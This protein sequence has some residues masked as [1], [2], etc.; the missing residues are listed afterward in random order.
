MRKEATLEQWK[1]LYEVTMNI[2]DLKPWEYFF[3]MDVI[4]IILPNLDEP[5]YCNIMG[6]GGEFFGIGTYA[7]FKAI[8]GFYKV[9]NNHTIPMAQIPRYQHLVMCNFGNRDE[10]RKDQWELVKKLGYKF[11]GKNNWIYFNSHEPGY[12][13]YIPDNEEVI[14]LTEVFKNLFIAIRTYIENDFEVDFKNGETLLRGYDEKIQDWYTCNAPILVKQIKYPVP[15]IQD[16]LLVNKLKK[17]KCNNGD[18]EIDRVYLNT[19][20]NNKNLERPILPKMIVLSDCISGTILDYRMLN[21]EDDEIE[22]TLSCLINYIKQLGRPKIIFVR[23]EY[24]ETILSDLC[25]KIKIELKIRG[26]L[27]YIDEFVTSINRFRLYR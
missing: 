20:I 11:R 25:K 4:T 15:I 22:K 17:A 2:K 26:N 9:G 24:I 13:P 5:V 19:P 14:L 16:E 1:E 7:G 12:T 21:K 27:N 6:R 8:Y 3:D 23:D 10:L 18:V